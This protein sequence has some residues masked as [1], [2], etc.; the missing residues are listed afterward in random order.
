[1]DI[2]TSVANSVLNEYY[3][4][5][6]YAPRPPTP[7]Y[8]THAY[9]PR[10]HIY[11][12]YEPVR[13]IV[14]L[15][16]PTL[17]EVKS[18]LENDLIHA[19]QKV[20]YIEN[21]LIKINRLIEIE[22]KD[23][24]KITYEFISEIHNLFSKESPIQLSQIS[25]KLPHSVLPPKVKGYYKLLSSWLDQVPGLQKE[26]VVHNNQYLQIYY[27]QSSYIANLL[28]ENKQIDKICWQKKRN[29]PCK[30]NDKGICKYCTLL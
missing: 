14:E 19:K 13:N 8:P 23:K 12:P 15:R 20:N 27:L 21:E 9:A 2:P 5:H 4:T 10:P 16:S 17:S 22:E 1:M 3:P 28:P 11:E 6:V 30:L 26:T 24:C 25:H 18:S 7:L 29:K